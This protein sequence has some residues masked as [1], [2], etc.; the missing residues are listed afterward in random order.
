VHPLAHSAG[1]A[2]PFRHNI[3]PK[4]ELKKLDL[5]AAK[6]GMRRLSKSSKA[7]WWNGVNRTGGACSAL[8]PSDLDHVIATNNLSF[9]QYKNADVR[10]LGWHRTAD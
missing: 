3:N 1:M 2:Y 10:V 5:A 6:A 7:T 8:P 4:L 9:E